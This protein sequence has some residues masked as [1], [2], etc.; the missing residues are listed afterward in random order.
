MHQPRRSK[1]VAPLAVAI[2]ALASSG[3]GDKDAE[4]FLEAMKRADYPAAHAQLHPEARA[5]TAD[6]AAI[7]KAVKE[8]GIELLGYSWT[9]SSSGLSQK[10][11]GYNFTT[12]GKEKPRPPVIVG[13][14]P[15]RK[16]KCNT[17]LVVDLKKDDQGVWRVLGMKLE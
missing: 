10:R 15:Q 3:C 2:L 16:G 4:Q 1:L 9:C 17:G 14:F 8:A 6:A 5:T 13:V 11:V 12:R 7:Q